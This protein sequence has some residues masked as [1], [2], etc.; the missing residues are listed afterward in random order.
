MPQEAEAARMEAGE[1]AELADA[2]RTQLDRARGLAAVAVAAQERSLQGGRAA[3]AQARG[4]LRS[5]A[6]ALVPERCWL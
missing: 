1:L 3:Q 5:A 6:A 4:V 2:L